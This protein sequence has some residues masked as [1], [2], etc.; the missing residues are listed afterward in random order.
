MARF[1]VP[2]IV[3]V[4]T[5][6]MGS[7][8]SG[9]QEGGQRKLT[10]PGEIIGP[11]VIVV[12]PDSQMLDTDGNPTGRFFEAN[13]ARAIK[14]RGLPTQVVLIEHDGDVESLAAKYEAV[15]RRYNLTTI[16]CVD[17]G[18][19]KF[20]A[21]KGNVHATVDQDQETFEAARFGVSLFVRSVDSFNC[22]GW[23]WL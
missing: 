20:G 2:V 3:S 15:K 18:G 19:D 14:D 21:E 17:T 23:Y 8:G 7:A 1:Q 6:K 22:S 13:I 10:S 5:V 16:V 11:G 4:R 12:T 9:G